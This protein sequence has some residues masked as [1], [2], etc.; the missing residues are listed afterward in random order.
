M[1]TV[2][3]H[4]FI[5]DQLADAEH[6]EHQAIYGPFFPEDNVT[7]E[8]LRDYARQCVEL[9]TLVQ[10]SPPHVARALIKNFIAGKGN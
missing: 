3:I 8:Y 5:L 4:A 9:A 7:P 10:E 1:L 2:D 6:A